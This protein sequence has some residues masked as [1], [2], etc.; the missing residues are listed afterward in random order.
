MQP[1]PTGQD[2][3][4]G[5]FFK[6]LTDSLSE[7]T[8]VEGFINATLRL[9]ESA[10]EINKV[11]TQGRQRIIELQQSVADTV[12]GINRLGGEIGD[13]LITISEIAQASRRNVVANSESVE[14]LYAASKILGVSARDLSNYFLDVGINVSQV[15]ENLQESIKYVQSIG[16]NAKEVVST[17]VT[18]MDQLNRYQ[19]EGGVQGLTKMAAQA[20][21]LRFNMNETFALAEKVLSPEGAIETAAA[22]QRLGVSVG[23]LVD[24]FQLMNQSINDPSGLQTSLSNVAKQFTYFDEKTKSFKINPQGVLM[25][26]ELEQQT[27]VSARELSKMG[28]AAAELDKRLSVISSAGLKVGSE[29]D[30]QFLANI[31]RMGEGGEY[32]VQIKDDRGQQQ[33][34]K[35]SEIT[36]TEFDKLIKEQKEG[37][38]TLEEL[39][40]SQMNVT[41]LLKGDVEAI[42]NKLLYGIASATPITKGFEG[43]RELT[44]LLGGELSK[45]GATKD[46]RDRVDKILYGG[47]KEF[48][49]LIRGDKTALQTMQSVLLKTGNFLD[50]EKETLTSAIQKVA[51]KIENRLVSQEF[52]KQ[53]TMDIIKKY[54]PLSSRI[55][56][57]GANATEKEKILR[58]QQEVKNII[59]SYG[60]NAQTNVEMG[61]KLGIQVNITGAQSLTPEQLKE[62]EKALTQRFNSLEFREYI[63]KITQKS[64]PTKKPA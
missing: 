38:K 60:V 35:L 27:G 61:G 44:E 12:P 19:F 64:N 46:V 4:I 6:N 57:I 10:V 47:L 45:V 30:K 49:E 50:K 58:I 17:M 29:E 33:T 34:K 26:R 24:P 14:E 13:V 43:M 63:L 8:K 52:T 54:N 2:S 16:G 39:A 23:N 62:I 51:E 55:E 31:A 48:T 36:Q 11:F 5:D 40:R 1:N 9:T 3:S 28:L 20:S 25:M 22:F 21:M 32:E 59:Q 15:G 18:N 56:P 41:Q 53:S 37:P 7:L 42:K